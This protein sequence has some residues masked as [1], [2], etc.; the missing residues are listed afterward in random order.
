M[1]YLCLTLLVAL[2]IPLTAQKF[3]LIQEGAFATDSTNTNGA[4]FVDYDNDGDLDIFLSNASVPFGF[5]TLYRNDGND[6]FT[7]VD[8]G[9]VTNMQT[10]TFGHTWGDYD[11][12]GLEDLF[13]VNAFTNIG[14]LLYRN[15]GNGKFQR[16]EN[17]NVGRYNVMGFAANWRDYDQDGLLDLTVI[18]PAGGF[19]GLP[20]TSNFLFKNN[21]DQAGSFTPILTTPI[22]RGTAPFT[23]ATWTD[24]DQD[25]D[26]DLFIGSGPANGTKRPD[27]HFKNLLAETGKANFT[28]ITNTAFAQ[29]SLDGQTWNWIDYDN[30]G[31]L[32]AY[33]TNWGGAL[34][35]IPN[36][37]YQ[38]E[39]DTIIRVDKGAIT[40]D[41]GISLANV[42]ADFDN[43]GD[44]DAY[45]GNGGNQPN[46]YYENL[47]NGTFKSITTG[48]FVGTQKNTWAVSAGD[49]N[50]DGK[51]DL[52][53]ATK[54]GYIRGRGDINYLYRNDT[55][56][57][58][59]WVLIKCEGTKSNRSG[60]GA[61]LKLTATINGSPITQIREIGSNA[62]FLGNNDKRAHFG[63]GKATN[64]DKIEITWPSG[65]KD[66][67]EDMVVNQILVA[68]EGKELK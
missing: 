20:T 44:V 25:G 5:N 34:G 66:V 51:I 7:Q 49:Y 42:W 4:S 52:L 17:Y 18:H 2:F 19:V 36:N 22:T 29:D 54:T 45:V 6:Q 67:Y 65:Q 11:N 56:N 39:S 41:V 10:V 24:Y 31:D 58:N 43:D 37:F 48:H 26:A 59:N 14:S 63:L 61:Q 27:Y 28:R 64:I 8:A 60:I 3:T 38:T 40:N 21:G 12:D 46:R 68:K 9:E 57:N 15:L 32:D 35:G 47:G 50:N 33:V 55:N 30:D 23:N 53:V 62:T 1:K 16:N 13:V